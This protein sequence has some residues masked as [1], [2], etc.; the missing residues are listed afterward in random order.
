MGRWLINLK[1]TKMKKREPVSHIMTSSLTT[2]NVGNSLREVKNLFRK[3]G[4]RHL[5]VVS[6]DA[7]VG[8][9]SETDIRRLSF[10]SN[11]GSE[12]NEADAAVFDMLTISQI[13]K[14][15]PATVDSGDTIREVAEKLASS[16][17]HALPVTHGGK[18]VGIVTST[19]LIK[20]LLEQ[21]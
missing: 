12:H 6:G 19:D 4:I 10:G 9:L 7:I 16:E 5:P 20:Y 21:Y 2:V 18:L 15:N 8:I 11:F 1:G 13:M 17:F 14:E 3:K